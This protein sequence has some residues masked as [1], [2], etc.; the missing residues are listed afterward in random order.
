MPAGGDRDRKKEGWKPHRVENDIKDTAEKLGFTA[1]QKSDW[2]AVFAFHE[3]YQT[4]D[5][6]PKT[7]V[8]LTMDDG[9]SE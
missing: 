9:A 8:T 2:R 5:S 3:Q 4:A 7:P 6:V 1:S